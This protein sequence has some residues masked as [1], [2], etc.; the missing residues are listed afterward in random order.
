MLVAV[1]DFGQFLTKIT[2]GLGNL[3]GVIVPQRLDNVP[4][5]FFKK[6]TNDSIKRIIYNSYR[7]VNPAKYFFY[8][9]REK[10]YPV[11]DKYPR[12]IIVGVKACDLKAIGI[13]DEAL[14]KGNFVEPTYS[15]WRENTIII[16]SDCD[17]ITDTCHCSLVGGKPFALLNYDG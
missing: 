14:L 1:D 6:L 9:T 13:L 17:E 2:A 12:R 10:V 15:K 8:T 7:T 16:S 11:A 4:H 5:L 3:G